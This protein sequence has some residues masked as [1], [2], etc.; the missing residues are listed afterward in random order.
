MAMTCGR[1]RPARCSS[2]TALSRIAESLPPGVDDREA[3]SSC[4]RRTA[5]RSAWTARACIQSTLPLQRVDFAVVA[6]V[7]ERVGQLPGRE[8]VG[9]EALVHQA[10]RADR[11]RVGQLAVEV[12]DLRRQQQSLVDD[13][14]RRE[15]RDVEEALVAACPEAATSASARLRTTYSLRSS[16]SWSMP[17]RAPDED[18]LDVGL[19]GARDAADG[20]GVD[21]ACRASPARSSPSS[22]TIRSRMPS[23]DQALLRLDRQED[24]ADAVLARAAAA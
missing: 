21:R 4:R 3:A 23:H 17:G 19:R 10:Q 14:A 1:L 20:V 2:S 7:A 15:R 18:L 13:G 9:G 8:R 6:D 16:A 12:G 11:V 24:H 22:R 5:A